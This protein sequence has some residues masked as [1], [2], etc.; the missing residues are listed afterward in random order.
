[1]MHGL[2]AGV[3]FSPEVAR[4]GTSDY[5]NG[6][7]FDNEPDDFENFTEAALRYEATVA[8]VKAQLGGGYSMAG[9]EANGGSFN[10]DYTEWNAGVALSYK[11]A[12][13]GAGYNTD[14][15][16]RDSGG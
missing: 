1:D 10:D 13:V 12:R 4:L 15:G 7:D 11:G 2:R 5:T 3:S 8:G 9:L 6:M 14:N 16:A